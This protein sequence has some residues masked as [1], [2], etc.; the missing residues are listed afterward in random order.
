M[1]PE[2]NSPPPKVF[3]SYARAD[4]AAALR[5]AKE[6]KA[7]GTDAWLD[8]LDITPGERWDTEIE[9]GLGQSQCVLVLL[10][11][12]SVAST[13]V[14]D[15]VSY[16]LDEG[17]EI[18]PVVIEKCK[19]PLRLRRFQYLDFTQDYD[20]SLRSLVSTLNAPQRAAGSESGGGGGR[21]VAPPR[22]MAGGAQH[23]THAGRSRHHNLFVGSAA[24]GG[25]LVFLI[26]VLFGSQ[27]SEATMISL[28]Y[29]WVPIVVFGAAGLTFTRGSLKKSAVAAVAALL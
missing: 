7:A 14:M 13:N 24:L 11:P 29:L 3:M 18:L 20:A 22:D 26:Y 28:S 9:K 2:V 8:Q 15:E 27:I 17:K 1:E 23:P 4:S 16:A 10:T 25:F 12:T 6:L 5:L 19:I 21:R